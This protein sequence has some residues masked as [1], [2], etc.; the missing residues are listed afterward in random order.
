MIGIQ[1]WGP[2]NHQLYVLSTLINEDNDVNTG[3]FTLPFVKSA[4][5]SYLHSVIIYMCIFY[6]LNN[7]NY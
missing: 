6:L 3:L 4:L 1:F 2:G 5:T 7:N